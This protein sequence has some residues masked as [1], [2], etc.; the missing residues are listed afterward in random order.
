MKKTRKVLGLDKKTYM[1]LDKISKK[2]YR[3]KIDQ[4][5]KWI[6]E[7]RKTGGVA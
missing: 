1:D 5:R 2:N 4:I 3:S 6:A 7:E